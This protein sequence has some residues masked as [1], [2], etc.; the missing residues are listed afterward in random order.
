MSIPSFNPYAS[1]YRPQAPMASGT[2]ASTFATPAGYG[3]TTLSSTAPVRMG[4]AA[5]AA[6]VSGHLS[7]VARAGG[8]IGSRA[9]MAGEV[10]AGWGK[11][12][13]ISAL[14]TAPLVALSDYMAFRSG[15]I[16][17]AQRNTLMAADTAGYVAAGAAG[18]WL[19]GALA[20]S[21]LGPV[22]MVVGI[23]ASVGL[24]FLYERYLRPNFTTTG[25]F[26]EPV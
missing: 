23:A 13:G 11:A 26:P 14:I 15:K 25:G 2:M 7:S 9:A 17:A 20:G 3:A 16:T 4:G 1:S 21:F 22:G 19:G 24:G 18:S 10:G 12:L 5:G 8:R 6:L